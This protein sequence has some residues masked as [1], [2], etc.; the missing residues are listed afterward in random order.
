MNF[1]VQ[2]V[3]YKQ[4]I[5]PHQLSRSYLRTPHNQ[6]FNKSVP[7]LIESANEGLI[8]KE[9]GLFVVSAIARVH[10]NNCVPAILVNST[11]RRFHLKRGNVLA[12]MTPV[13]DDACQCLSTSTSSTGN[14]D[15][16]PKFS[17]TNLKID[18][19]N[20]SPK[21]V[22]NLRSLLNEFEDV[23]A[24]HSH[25]IGK[26]KGIQVE[27]PLQENK[28]ISRPQYKIPLSV[29]PEVQRQIKQMLKF[30]IIEKADIINIVVRE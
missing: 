2:T 17:I 12:Q 25:D 20:V 16:D 5:L 26:A 22:D 29:Q 18:N 21:D 19:P 3:W 24:T 30:D 28:I 15:I 8:P 14:V 23:F 9:P 27:I 7:L 13:P 1:L 10:D 4:S 11:G 6:F